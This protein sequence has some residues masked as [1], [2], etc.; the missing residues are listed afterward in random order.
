[1][2]DNPMSGT[3]ANVA[4]MKPT[5]ALSATTDIPQTV[6]PE[7]EPPSP[8][9]SAAPDTAT[10]PAAS[11]PAEPAA[12]TAPDAETGA[13]PGAEP[14]EPPKKNA[15]SERLS[16]LAR[17]RNEEKARA[18]RALDAVG[19]LREELRT[20]VAALERASQPKPADPPEPVRPRRQDYVDPD[21]YEDAF[22]D[23]AEQ[24]AASRA[25]QVAARTADQRA[26]EAAELATKTQTE[27]TQRQMVETVQRDFQQRRNAFAAEHEDYAEVAERDDLQ[28]TTPMAA[29][30][31][32][33]ERGPAIAYHLGHHPEE[34][35]RIASLSDP[36]QQ[37]YEMGILGAKLTPPPKPE[38]SRAT[39]PITP[40]IGTNADA[41]PKDPNDMTTEEWAAQREPALRAER[42]ASTLGTRV[43]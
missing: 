28:I 37:L 38:V 29:A 19:S 14:K 7:T 42:R 30:I 39:P 5:P 26:K 31:M 32:R 36:V 41:G 8:G 10:A 25:E 33:S 13:E 4:L 20:A 2:A 9:G 18:D 23:W 12:D 17:Q 27:Q 34:A 43:N 35:Q 15:F 3:A 11:P 6:I 24:R 16:D 1:M 22:A 40:R 21:A